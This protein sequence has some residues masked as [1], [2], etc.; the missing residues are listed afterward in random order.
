MNPSTDKYIF[1]Y[2]ICDVQIRKSDVLIT[3]KC[4]N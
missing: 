2:L 4:V 3:L 1:Y